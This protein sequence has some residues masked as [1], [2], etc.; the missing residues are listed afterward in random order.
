MKKKEPTTPR[1]RTVADNFV[2]A[3]LVSAAIFWAASAFLSPQVDLLEAWGV[4]AEASVFSAKKKFAEFMSLRYPGWREVGDRSGLSSTAPINEIEGLEAMFSSLKSQESR[5]LYTFF[6]H[7]VFATCTWAS[8]HF[9]FVYCM[10][11]AVL[12]SYASMAIVLG[13]GTVTEQK[14]FW[15]LYG[16]IALVAGI[17]VEAYMLNSGLN[18]I[19]V[20]DGAFRFVE[21][22]SFYRRLAFAG[23]CI[24]VAA[25]DA[26]TVKDSDRLQNVL[27]MQRGVFNRLAGTRLAKAAVFGDSQ[28]RSKYNEYHRQ[29]EAHIEAM[30]RSTEYANA[31]RETLRKLNIG[32][33][34]QEASTMSSNI[35]AAARNE[36]IITSVDLPPPEPYLAEDQP[37]A[38]NSTKEARREGKKKE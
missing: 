35:I 9:D 27:E 2:T 31:R 18:N 16:T 19:L 8:E 24:I 33:M 7:S 32:L 10:L 3:F 28:L 23:L 25:M 12:L 15:R 38:Q 36:G 11:P 26:G 22:A 17:V 29:E 4:S 34:V 37:T 5:K 6:G 14:R 20:P 1:V 13:V 30:H 21:S